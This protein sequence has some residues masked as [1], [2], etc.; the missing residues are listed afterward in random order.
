MATLGKGPYNSGAVAAQLAKKTTQ[1]GPHRDNLIRRG[2]IYSRRY[3]EIDFTV[4]MFDEYI[5]RS[6]R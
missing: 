5:R 3:G 4:P 2:L 1:V 6:L